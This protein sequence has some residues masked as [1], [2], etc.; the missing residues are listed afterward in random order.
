MKRVSILSLL[1]TTAFGTAVPAF[2]QTTN[3]SSILVAQAA[4][5]SFIGL[6][7]RDLPTGLTNLGGWLIDATDNGTFRFG[8][9]HIRQNTKKMLWLERFV[10]RDAKGM[11]TFRV[12]DVIELPQISQSQS[13]L[14][15]RF[16]LR[17]GKED[18]NLVTIVETADTQYWT[19][20]HQAWRANRATGKFEAISTKGIVCQNPGWGV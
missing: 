7:Y 9:S 10:R 4:P 8:I 17:N 19:A 1:A 5:R 16:C 20:I 13:V 12:V 2:S 11:P 15:Y 3:Q 18:L 6:P 14:G